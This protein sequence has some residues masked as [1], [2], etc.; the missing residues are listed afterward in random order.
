MNT[1]KTRNSKKTRKKPGTV[2]F[3]THRCLHT[4]LKD[5]FNVQ[6][7]VAITSLFNYLHKSKRNTIKMK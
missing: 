3:M 2:L 5:N 6:D 1:Q 7:Q 4:T